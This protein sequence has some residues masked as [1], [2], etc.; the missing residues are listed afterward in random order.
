[1]KQDFLTLKPE[2]HVPDGGTTAVQLQTTLYQR[3]QVQQ[4][5]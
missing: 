1:M 2:E 5:T 4:G 3:Q